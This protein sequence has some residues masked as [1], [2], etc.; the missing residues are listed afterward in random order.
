MEAVRG[1]IEQELK[2]Y[3]AGELFDESELNWLGYHFLYWWGREKE[4][5]EVFKLLVRLFP[6]SANAFD[7]LAEAY[8]RT[9]KTELAIENYRISLKLNPDNQNAK[10][11]L[12]QLEK[13]R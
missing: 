1:E 2:L 4:A 5:V 3:P 13:Q 12:K 6:E 10:E 8:L 11:M 9:G 7:S